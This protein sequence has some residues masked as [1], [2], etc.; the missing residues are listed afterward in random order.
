MLS[1]SQQL[2]AGITLYGLYRKHA[3]VRGYVR[4]VSKLVP[5]RYRP[6]FDL[7]K[8]VTALFVLAAACVICRRS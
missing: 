6:S 5:G 8:A 7:K 3:L 2:R 1:A 4:L